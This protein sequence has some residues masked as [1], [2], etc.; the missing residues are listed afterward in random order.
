MMWHQIIWHPYGKHL[1]SSKNQ[2]CNSRHRRT[3]QIHELRPSSRSFT[4]ASIDARLNLKSLP[5]PGSGIRGNF[6]KRTHF[7]SVFGCTLTFA[8]A[9]ISIIKAGCAVTVGCSALGRLWLTI[10][11]IPGGSHSIVITICEF[12]INRNTALG[13]FRLTQCGF[14][15]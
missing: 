13:T 10:N 3:R 15:R 9:S 1:K 7:R 6:P 12:T 5:L 11:V 2:N 8:A 14:Y 4:H